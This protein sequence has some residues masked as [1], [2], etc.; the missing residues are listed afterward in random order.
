MQEKHQ[1]MLKNTGKHCSLT[2]CQCFHTPKMF[3]MQQTGRVRPVPCCVLSGPW[4]WLRSELSARTHFS[5]NG[6]SASMQADHA[7]ILIGPWTFCT[8][9]PTAGLPFK[10]QE[11]NGLLYQFESIVCCN[12]SA[13]QPVLA[14]AKTFPTRKQSSLTDFFC[15]AADWCF[16]PSIPPKTPTYC[17]SYCLSY[18]DVMLSFFH[19]GIVKN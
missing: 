19:R 17:L 10:F 14:K 3:I 8:Y 16:V 2:F 11:S 4:C 18:V 13:P 15:L 7:T 9:Q 1:C 5:F 12:F 6:C